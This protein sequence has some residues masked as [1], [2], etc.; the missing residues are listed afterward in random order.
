MSKIDHVVNEFLNET[1]RVQ[2][3]S[4]HKLE[5]A[6]Y[7]RGF[8][9]KRFEYLVRHQIQRDLESAIAAQVQEATAQAKEL[10]GDEIADAVRA[11]LLKKLK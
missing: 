4:E 9:M 2:W 10:M 11:A 7:G 6:G 5:M 8:E 3:S 1:L